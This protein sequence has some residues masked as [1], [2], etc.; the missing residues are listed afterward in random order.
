[1]LRKNKKKLEDSL[2]LL[3]KESQ[4][5]RNI[6]QGLEDQVREAERGKREAEDELF[7]EKSGYKSGLASA[8]SKL[9]KAET[10]LSKIKNELELARQQAEASSKEVEVARQEAELFREEVVQ[11]KAKVEARVAKELEE[12]E[13]ETCS[14]FLFTLWVE[15]PELNF[16]FFSEEA[17]EEVKKFVVEAANKEAIPTSLMPNQIGA[18]LSPE[19]AEGPAPQDT[20]P[21]S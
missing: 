1:M 19:V 4:R 20:T 16:S 18:D 2:A 9:D 10:E 15:H 12:V 7:R 6:A 5:A 17:V 13:S 11:K 8:T 14:Q 3:T 21:P